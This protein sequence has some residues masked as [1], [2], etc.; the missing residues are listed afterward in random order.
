MIQLLVGCLVIEVQDT[1]AIMADDKATL[2]HA[3]CDRWHGEEVHRRNR[4]PVILK[5]CAPRRYPRRC[6]V[7]SHSEERFPESGDLQSL[8]EPEGVHSLFVIPSLRANPKRGIGFEEAQVVF[9]HP[10]YLDQR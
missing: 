8:P 9:S 3:E 4:F 2:E 7:A 1:A 10:Y 5:K 6:G